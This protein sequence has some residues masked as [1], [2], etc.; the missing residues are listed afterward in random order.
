MEENLP[1]D[2]QS[3]DEAPS[4][5]E[6]GSPERKGSPKK[7]FSKLFNG[8]QKNLAEKKAKAEQKQHLKELGITPL[9]YQETIRLQKE[10][11]EKKLKSKPLPH[12][13]CI[14]LP[15]Y[16]GSK[17][18]GSSRQRV[19]SDSYLYHHTREKSPVSELTKQISEPIQHFATP[20]GTFTPVSFEVGMEVEARLREEPEIHYGVIRWI[21]TLPRINRKIAGVELVSCV[22]AKCH[23]P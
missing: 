2:V 12:Q 20:N 21:G 11:E 18:L 8:N 15:V 14:D 17:G 5:S 19:G 7:F 16:D 1:V 6:K 9:E 10:Y 4:N 23:F 22:F 13:D 3:L